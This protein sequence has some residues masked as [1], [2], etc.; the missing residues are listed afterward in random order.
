[1]GLVGVVI[2]GLIILLAEW[3][4]E[5]RSDRYSRKAGL[6]LLCM[7]LHK[8]IAVTEH[9]ANDGTWGPERDPLPTE[10]YENHSA[11]LAKVLPAKRWKLVEG[12]VLGVKRI[13]GIRLE[14]LQGSRTASAGEIADIRRIRSFIKKA[15]K[16]IDAELTFIENPDQQQQ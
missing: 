15:L 12:A 14:I 3:M 8:V 16:E 1:M 5:I 13:E 7:D 2:G 4:K 11:T 10:G 6:R 9:V